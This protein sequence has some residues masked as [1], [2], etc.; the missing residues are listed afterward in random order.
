MHSPLIEAGAV[1]RAAQELALN[2]AATANRRPKALVTLD[3]AI[4]YAAWVAD[5][6]AAGKLD[7]AQLNAAD[8]LLDRFSQLIKQRDQEATVERMT[9]TLADLKAARGE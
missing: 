2:A 3:D 8:R 4:A 5:R 1:H 9:K 6:F 7:V